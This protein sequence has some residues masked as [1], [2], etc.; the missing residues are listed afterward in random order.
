MNN[1]RSTTRQPWRVDAWAPPRFFVIKEAT[2]PECQGFGAVPVG[3]SG[4]ERCPRCKGKGRVRE[5]V[6]ITEAFS[7]FG[8]IFYLPPDDSSERGA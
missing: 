4:T 8:V 3:D 1:Q 6:P 7:Q 5:E 2:C